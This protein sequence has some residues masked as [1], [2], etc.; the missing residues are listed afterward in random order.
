MNISQATLYKII[1]EEYLREEGLSLS[2]AKINQAAEDLLKR[3]QG[4]KYRP[5][6]ER[7]PARY[8]NK[9]GN[10]S[11]MEKPHTPADETMPIPADDTAD[12]DVGT[13]PAEESSVVDQIAALVQGLDPEEVAEIFQAVFVNV[14]GVELEEPDEEAPETLYSPGAEGR[15]QVGFKLE[16]LMA[17]VREVMQ[18]SGW[19]DAFDAH[20]SVA[21]QTDAED[22]EE[23]EYERMTDAQLVH[24]AHT[25]GYEELLVFNPEAGLENREELIAT[26]KDEV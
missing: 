17:L 4:D 23:E 9:D 5:P 12:I 7:D 22:S 2:E 13:P 24:L 10:T 21:A 11:P 18:E 3:I 26:L 1:I 25:G 6:E 19:Q 8:A 15:P 14:P 16:E 20:L